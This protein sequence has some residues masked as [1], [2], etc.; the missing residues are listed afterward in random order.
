MALHRRDGMPR[1]GHEGFRRWT[2]P[3]EKR[4]RAERG[5]GS[6]KGEK[7]GEG[8]GQHNVVWQLRKKS[9]PGRIQM[10]SPCKVLGEKEKQ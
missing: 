10:L 6:S 2:A 1:G 7:K 4:W 9:V 3:G 8:Q 5:E